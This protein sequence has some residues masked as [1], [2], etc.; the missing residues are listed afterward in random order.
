MLNYHL[1]V[2]SLTDIGQVRPT[3]EDRVAADGALGLAFVADGMGGHRGGELAS[4]IAQ[5]VVVSRVQQ[6]VGSRKKRPSGDF[7]RHLFAE[8]DKAILAAAQKDPNVRGMGTT[9]AMAL[10]HDDRVVLGHIGD[11]RVYRL[12]NG[13]L[14]A[15]T[16]DDTLLRDQ[17]EMGLIEAAHA[18]DSHNRHL[19]TRA[20]GTGKGV[21]PH[22]R[23]EEA[24]CGDVF[25]LCTDGLNDMVDDDDIELILHSLGCN[26]PLA[27]HHLVQLANDNGGQD[28]ISAVLVRLDPLPRVGRLAAWF[29]RLFGR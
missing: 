6:R 3:N 5:Q 9:L 16:R 12:R 26:L 8:A 2:A 21:T 24:R 13:R 11:C 20:L 23:D 15:L 28:N 4:R 18:A 29:G 25:L 27:A 17:V 7:V 10:F 1:E 22:L 19:V 14:E